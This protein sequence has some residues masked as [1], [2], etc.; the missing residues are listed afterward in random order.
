MQ[1]ITSQSRALPA[2]AALSALVL[3]AISANIV[4]ASLVRVSADFG[5]DPRY[6]A[7]VTAIQFAGFFIAS[8]VGGMLADVIGKK[9]V[10]QGGCIFV[11]IGALVWSR[12]PALPVA[13][14]GGFVMGLGGGVLESMSSALLTDLFPD[15][16]KFYLNMSQIAYCLGAIGG[17]AV[18]GRLLPMGVS[19][20]WFFLGTAGFSI[21]IF[22]LFS[23]S[24]IAKKKKTV[25][26]FKDVTASGKWLRLH[27]VIP[28]FALFL[29]VFAEMG[30]LTFMAMYLQQVLGAPENWALYGI[31]IF[32]GGMIIGRFVCAFIPEDHSYEITIGSLCILGAAAVLAQ[33][34]VEDWRFSIVCFGLNGLAYAGIWP[35]IVGMAAARSSARDSGRVVGVTVASGAL[36]CIVAPPVLGFIFKIYSADVMFAFVAAQLVLALLLM[37]VGW[38]KLRRSSLSSKPAAAAV[39]DS[40]RG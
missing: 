13:F 22:S 20:R 33:I 14:A 24:R 30:V 9:S 4:V 40:S 10:L 28:C 27:F 5:M 16:R 3:F 32:W 26:E 36:G 23:F 25:S 6:V 2:A 38:L 34:F 29:Y 15:K 37:F 35:L 39:A 12:A 17:P 8:I 31:G 18:M 1:R 7:N 19:W 11:A 21:A